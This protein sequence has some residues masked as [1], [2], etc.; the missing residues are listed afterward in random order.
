MIRESCSV[1]LHGYVE[2]FPLA[3]IT[4]GGDIL[5]FEQ[6][7]TI[8]RFCIFIDLSKLIESKEQAISM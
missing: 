6:L 1:V 4:M 5:D 2:S 8:V 7:S 3:T